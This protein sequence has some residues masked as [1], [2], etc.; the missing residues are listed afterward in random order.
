M[1]EVLVTLVILL[2]GLLGLAGMLTQSQ[3]AE[4]ESYQR[5]QALILLQDMVERINT[6][7]KVA[8]CYGISVNPVADFLG[9][10]ALTP[11]A[12]TSG[13]AGQNTRVQ[14]DLTAWNNALLGAAETRGGAQV[15]AMIG[16]RGCIQQT[17]A[18]NNIYLISVAWQ[19]LSTTFSPIATCAQNQYGNDA[20]RRVVTASLRIANLN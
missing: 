16:A 10:G 1:I 13:T 8:A 15:G 4:L 20:Q 7:R 2:T 3:K 17:D 12:C 11:V 6:N 14:E 5:A 19:G 9:N 18:T